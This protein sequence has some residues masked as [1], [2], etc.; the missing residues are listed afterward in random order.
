MVLVR[1]YELKLRQA[2][3]PYEQKFFDREI[4]SNSDLFFAVQILDIQ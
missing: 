2:C 3:L 1:V 4:L